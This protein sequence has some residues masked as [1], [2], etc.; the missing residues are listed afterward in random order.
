MSEGSRYWLR[1][2]K[3]CLNVMDKFDNKY[4]QFESV[5]GFKSIRNSF[6]RNSNKIIK[7]NKVKWIDK[8]KAIEKYE[9]H[10]DRRIN[11]LTNTSNYNLDDIELFKEPNIFEQLKCIKINEPNDFLN[12]I[13]LYQQRKY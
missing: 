10:I 8:H 4:K 11:R 13:N 3:Y 7:L 5:E 6:K 9:R 1:H 12:S 2:K